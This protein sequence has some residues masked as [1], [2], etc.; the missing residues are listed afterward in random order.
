MYIFQVMITTTIATKHVFSFIFQEGG[1]GPPL[2]G[3]GGGS[4]LRPDGGF[5][6]QNRIPDFQIIKSGS[7]LIETLMCILP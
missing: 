5:N 4:R 6:N 7:Y 3:D 2:Y 1:N